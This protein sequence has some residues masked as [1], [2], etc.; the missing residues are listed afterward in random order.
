MIFVDGLKVLRKGVGACKF[1]G[2]DVCTIVYFIRDRFP[3]MF[4]GEETP[5]SFTVMMNFISNVSKVFLSCRT[6]PYLNRLSVVYET[7]PIVKDY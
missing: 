5:K 2:K 7:F 3:F 6:N 4:E 1:V